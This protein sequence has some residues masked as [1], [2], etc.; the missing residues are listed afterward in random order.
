MTT[1]A[2]VFLVDDNAGVRKSVRA[3]MESADIAVEKYA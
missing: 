1:E 3:L 2:T